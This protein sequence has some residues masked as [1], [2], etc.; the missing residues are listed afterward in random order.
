MAKLRPSPPQRG[1]ECRWAGAVR[2]KSQQT[3]IR[4]RSFW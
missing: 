1:V 3:D 4:W 2:K